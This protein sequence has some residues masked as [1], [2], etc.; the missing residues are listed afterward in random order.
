MRKPDG[1]VVGEVVA[2]DGDDAGVPEAAALEDSEVGRAAADIDERDAQL[3]LVL[4]EDRLAR[5]QLL[6]HRV[7]HRH[8]RP[9]HAGDDVLRGRGAAGH[10]V[11]VHFEPR[12]GHA[13]RRADAVLLVD[14]EVLRQ[15]VQDLAAARQRDRL[16]RVDRAPDVLARDL[17]VLAGHRHDAA[18][19]EGLDVRARQSEVDGID[20]DAGGEFRFVDRLLDRFDGRLEV[21]D[22]AAADPA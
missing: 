19:V 10:D 6:E 13:D 5:G 9:I 14:D 18:A 11:D 17:P 8:A 2:A 12:A 22:H 16:G 15:D 4:G 1:D 3:L 20:L 21:D 7:E